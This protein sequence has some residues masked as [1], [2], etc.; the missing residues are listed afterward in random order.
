MTITLVLFL[1]LIYINSLCLSVTFIFFKKKTIYVHKCVR[2]LVL[3]QKATKRGRTCGGS[4][5]HHRRS[6]EFDELLTSFI[7]ESIIIYVSPRLKFRSK[8][9]ISDK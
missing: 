3:A 5:G 2:V 1:F 7:L 9:Q 8:C 4:D 6:P